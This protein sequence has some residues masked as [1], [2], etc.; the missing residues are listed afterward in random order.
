MSFARLGVL[1]IPNLKVLFRKKTTSNPETCTLVPPYLHSTWQG[2][3]LGYHKDA[4]HARPSNGVI[5]F[6]HLAQKGICTTGQSWQECAV[7]EAL[8]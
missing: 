8:E 4:R 1:I 7:S 6:G 2:L 3:D 5:I